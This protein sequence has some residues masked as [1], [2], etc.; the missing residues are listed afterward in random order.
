ML[1]ETCHQYGEYTHAYDYNDERLPELCGIRIQLGCEHAEACPVLSFADP[2]VPMVSVEAKS[3]P[4]V[5][6]ASAGTSAPEGCNSCLGN[7]GT[8]APHG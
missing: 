7:T 5:P 1:D 4:V 3:L 2:A 6:L 8:P